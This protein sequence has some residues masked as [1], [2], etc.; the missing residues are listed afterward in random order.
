MDP[1][2]HMKHYVCVSNLI[3]IVRVEVGKIKRKCN[4]IHWFINIYNYMEGRK[5]ILF[6]GWLGKWIL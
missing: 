6:T 1:G 4:N 3:V 2:E 5:L